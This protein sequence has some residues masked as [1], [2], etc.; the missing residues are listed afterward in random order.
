MFAKSNTVDIPFGCPA[1][2]V[3]VKPVGKSLQKKRSV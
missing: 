3:S 1:L 2:G